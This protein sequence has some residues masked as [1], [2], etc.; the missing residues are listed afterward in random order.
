MNEQIINDEV[1]CNEQKCS[2][3]INKN[4]KGYNHEIRIVEGTAKETIDKL[5][6][7][8][9]YANEKL[10]ENLNLLDSN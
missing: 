3:K 9:L 2:I 10:L 7:D 5:I 8:V 1:K 4:T 6:S